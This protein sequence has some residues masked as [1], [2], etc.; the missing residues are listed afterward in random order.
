[1]TPE[2]LVE[3]EQS[4]CDDGFSE[5]IAACKELMR[6]R[7]EDRKKGHDLWERTTY[8]IEKERDE[9][10]AENDR[11]RKALAKIWTE[12]YCSTITPDFYRRVV[13]T[14]GDVWREFNIDARAALE[15]K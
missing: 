8:R 15:T 11:L 9:L 7:D 13:K 3:I 5:L 4:F 10:R 14:I 6:E 1:M 12:A 2:R